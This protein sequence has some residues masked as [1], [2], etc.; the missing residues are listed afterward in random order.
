MNYH[1]VQGYMPAAGLEVLRR[2][3]AGKRVLEIGCWKGRTAIAMAEVAASVWSIDHFRGDAYAGPYNTLPEAWVN[4][5]ESGLPIRLL[6][7]PFIELLPALDL[8]LFDLVF[9]DGDHDFEPTQTFLRIALMGCRPDA[10]VVV[11]DYSPIYPQV[12]RAVAEALPDGWPVAV[13]GAL[14]I[15]QPPRAQ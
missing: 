11:D 5:I 7:G 1:D 15:F 10:V 3:A 8:S 9:Y 2:L 6:V 4:V 14:A 12:Q 13:I